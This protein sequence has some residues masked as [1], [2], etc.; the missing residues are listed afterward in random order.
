MRTAGILLL[1]LMVTAALAAPSVWGVPGLHRV[2]RAMPLGINEM[3]FGIGLNYWTAVNEYTN[4]VYHSHYIPQTLLFPELTETEYTGQGLLSL[5]Y[6][7]WDYVDLAATATYSASW[8]E[9]GLYEERST[10]HWEEIQGFEA[11]NFV[12]HGGYNPIPDLEDVVWFGGDIKLGFAPSD[13]MFLHCEDDPDGRW[14]TG[15]IISN[16]RRPFTTTGNGTFGADL[17]ISGDFGRWLPMAA[18]KAHLNL[19]YSKYTE[20]YH[21]TDFRVSLDS[22]GWNYSD[23]TIVDLEVSDGV[24]TWGIGIE[25][26]T[27]HADLFLEYTSQKLLDREDATVS[28]FT[29]GIRFKNASGTFIDITFDLSTT[30][31]DPLYYDLGHGLYQ[32]QDVVTPEQRAERAPLPIGGTFDYGIGLSI[33]FSSDMVA[34]AEGPDLCTLSGVVSDSITGQPVFATITF[35]GVAIANVTSDEDTGYYTHRIPAG[36]VPVA[37]VAPGYGTANALVVMNRN[38]SAN[39]DFALVPNL[40]TLSGSVRDGQGRPI[41]GATVT[42]GSPAPVTISTSTAGVFTAQV[43][44]GTWPVSVQADGFITDNKSVTSIANET[45]RVDFSLRAALREGEVMSFDNIYFDSGSA[46]IKPESYPILD[47]VAILLR[48]NP[49]ARMQVAGHTDSDGSESSNQ[50]LSER[51]AQSVYQYLVSKGIAGNRLTTVGYGE[52][53]PVAANDSAANKARNRRIEFTVL[54][55]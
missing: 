22:V 39:L 41:E 29:P 47:S 12:L 38:Q 43:E 44:A 18:A 33:G 15:Q 42:I 10:G 19:G 14:H 25:V 21:F 36:E 26:P 20:N 28:Y 16:A 5:A 52:S 31:F 24:F 48:D 27:P 3:S 49:T 40:G 17:L 30:E 4:F 11:I 53:N 32:D 51:R 55:I 8:Y 50:T 13:T 9:R 46:N 7:V 6:G 34:G 45:V 54:S 35:P 37:V 1:I 23:S 2:N